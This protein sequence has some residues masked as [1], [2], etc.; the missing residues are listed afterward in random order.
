MDSVDVPRTRVAG[1]KLFLVPHEHMSMRVGH[2]FVLVVI[3]NFVDNREHL[4]RF[5]HFFDVVERHV[6]LVR[7]MGFQSIE[8]KFRLLPGCGFFLSLVHSLVRHVC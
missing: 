2:R 6:S 4:P 1:L 3:T 8:V 5:Q 7:Q